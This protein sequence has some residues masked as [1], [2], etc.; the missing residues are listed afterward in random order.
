[1]TTGDFV[2]PE[3]HSE[4]NLQLVAVTGVV[5]RDGKVLAMRRAATKDAA[6]GAWETV[7]GRVEPGENPLDAI[8]REIDEETGLQVRIDP[9]PVDVYAAHRGATPMTVIVYRVEWV[10]G[11]VNRSAEHDAHA[12]WTPGEFEAN[13][14]LERLAEAIRRATCPSRDPSSP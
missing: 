8:V 11:E 1:M 4:Q 5:I 12:W 9:R 2:E 13:S 10:G 3:E 7:S 6:A 14:T